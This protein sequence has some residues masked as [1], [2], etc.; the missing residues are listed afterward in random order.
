MSDFLV[1]HFQNAFECIKWI[2]LIYLLRD[3]FFSFFNCFS[4]VI[5]YL[6]IYLRMPFVGI[7]DENEF[8]CHK[9]SQSVVF[10]F[11]MM[12]RIVAIWIVEMVGILMHVALIIIRNSFCHTWLYHE[13]NINERLAIHNFF[14]MCKYFLCSC[15]ILCLCICECACIAIVISHCIW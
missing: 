7:M 8:F 11:A 10:F 9:L 4:I 3:C 1:R 13:A 5:I 2:T 15:M 14:C 6:Y 12:F